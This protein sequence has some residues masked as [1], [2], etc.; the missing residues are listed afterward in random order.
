MSSLER[1]RDSSGLGWL[2]H[3]C[4]QLLVSSASSNEVALGLGGRADWSSCLSSS[5]GLVWASSHGGGGG[6][7]GSPNAQRIFKPLLVSC[8]LAPH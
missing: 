3:I 8:L 1:A 2:L 5:S 6:K 4:S 7:R